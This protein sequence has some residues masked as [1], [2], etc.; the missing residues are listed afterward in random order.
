MGRAEPLVTPFPA[1]PGQEADGASHR[2]V[3]PVRRSTEPPRLIVMYGAAGRGWKGRGRGRGC[4][5]TFFD[6]KGQFPCAARVGKK[7]RDTKP[8]RGILDDGFTCRRRK[9]H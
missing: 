3:S 8:L 1:L 6:I 9:Q 5:S 7:E 2:R 4:R